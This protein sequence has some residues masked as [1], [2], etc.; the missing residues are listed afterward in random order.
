[1]NSVTKVV[2][3]R[4]YG[5]NSLAGSIYKL[6][7]DDDILHLHDNCFGWDKNGRYEKLIDWVIIVPEDCIDKVQKECIELQLRSFRILSNK[8]MLIGG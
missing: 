7:K 3:I 6:L 4:H 1:M 2:D 8:G 5:A